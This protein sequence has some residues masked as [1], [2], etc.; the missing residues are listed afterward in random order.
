MAKIYTQI[1]NACWECPWSTECGDRCMKNCRDIDYNHVIQEWC[2]L[3]NTITDNFIC[4]L[5]IEE[6]EKCG[7]ECLEKEIKLLLK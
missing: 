6:C 2:P 5:P 1:I 4:E 3:P 7:V